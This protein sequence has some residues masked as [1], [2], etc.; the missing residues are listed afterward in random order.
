MPSPL[1]SDDAPVRVGL[2]LVLAVLLPV[3]VLAIAWWGLDQIARQDVEESIVRRHSKSRNRID[4]LLERHH[5]R[6]VIL[7]NSLSNTDLSAAVLEQVFDL[8]TGQVQ[9]LSMPGSI[10]AHWTAILENRIIEGGHRPDLVIVLSD[11]PSLLS[12][13]PQTES[14]YLT[15]VQQLDDEEPAF[16]RLIGERW[17]AL[18]RIRQDRGQLR[19][20]IVSAVRQASV[21]GL[22]GQRRGID[23]ALSRVFAPDALDPRLHQTALPVADPFVDRAI[24][25]FD[26]STIP[27]PAESF[28]PRLT[29]VAQDS[30]IA[31][32]LVRPPM[33]PRLPSGLGD[34][35][36]PTTEASLH[37]LVRARGAHDLDLRGLPMTV[38]HFLNLDHINPDGRIRF[39]R[40]VA[41]LIQRVGAWEASPTVLD[42][43]EPGRLVEGR[44][45]PTTLAARYA[46]P[47]PP[48]KAPDR[49][50]TEH[51]PGWGR[52]ALPGWRF[53]SDEATQDVTPWASRC[54]PI[55]VM[56]DGRPLPR[57]H[58][59]CGATLRFG[60]GR[61]CHDDD[62]IT[63]AP[64]EPSNPAVNGRTYTLALDPSRRC[65]R[66]QWLYPG[67]TLTLRG[68]PRQRATV[69]TLRIHEQST[70]A[71]AVKPSVLDVT[72]RQGAR[73]LVETRFEAEA[74][75]MAT[76][77][78]PLREPVL[79][80][81]GPVE[82]TIT[83]RSR[84]F[85]MV[86]EAKLRP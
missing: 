34:V 40:V 4:R 80:S 63:F 16:E 83:S 47:P 64:S 1:A 20:R 85:A 68:T 24:P 15:L 82:L 21:L 35:V 2:P 17:T 61:T 66:A 73:A 37:A 11:W 54:S 57:P 18:D 48:I 3:L 60:R 31:L 13:E 74:P 22:T 41:D 76:R 55:L 10:G 86:T 49:D 38:G 78:F 71:D 7:G 59:T 45:R 28:V 5:P 56:E 36:E 52:Y 84:R 29:E 58:E 14:G 69:L 23:D 25:V 79:P 8:A 50:L 70:A 53:L 44:Y 67:D 62:G 42:W 46:T 81:A 9:K 72:L 39:T 27:H 30:G 75:P 6:V 77:S 12:V 26:P 19:E 33:S 43:L 51:G 32:V 65:E